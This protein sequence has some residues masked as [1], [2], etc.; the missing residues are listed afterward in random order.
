MLGAKASLTQ[1]VM[2]ALKMRIWTS[3]EKNWLLVTIS[4]EAVYLWEYFVVKK[5]GVGKRI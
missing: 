1:A 5:L 3:A 2:K 4:E